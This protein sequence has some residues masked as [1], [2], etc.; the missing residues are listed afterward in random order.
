MNAILV[1][2]RNEDGIPTLD[3]DT[4]NEVYIVQ[5]NL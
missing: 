4:Q 3:V 1:I 2:E 5:R